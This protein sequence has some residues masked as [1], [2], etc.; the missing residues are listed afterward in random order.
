MIGDFIGYGGFFGWQPGVAGGNTPIAGGDRRF[1]IAE[2]QSPV[3]A[4]RVYFAYNNF[5]NA[6]RAIDGP[7]AFH[8]VNFERYTLGVEKAFLGDLFSAE[9]RI[10]IGHGLDSDLHGSP[11]ASLEGTEFGNLVL[12]AKTCLL[13]RP[14]WVASAG[15]GVSIPTADDARQFDSAGL[16]RSEIDNESFH[17]QPFVGWAWTP[18]ERFFAEV[19]SAVDFDPHGY[20]VSMAGPSGS[21]VDVGTYND[22]TLSM[23]DLKVGYWVYRACCRQAWLTGV[24]PTVEIHYTSTLEDHDDLQPPGDL[25]MADPLNRWYNLNLTVGLQ[26]LMRTGSTFAAFAVL[27]LE[28]DEDPVTGAKSNFDAEFGFQL[29]QYF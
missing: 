6:L 9:L 17:L 2:N 18:K 5:H 26:V 7:G 14:G 21:M 8:Q 10:P 12:V 25:V 3:P 29:N 28:D 27:P 20:D 1:K 22:Q 13:R 11:G 23:F 16:L 24:A 15:I 19:F 4:D